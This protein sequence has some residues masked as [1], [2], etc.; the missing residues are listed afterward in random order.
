[1]CKNWLLVTTAFER[2]LNICSSYCSCSKD[3]CTNPHIHTYLLCT[4]PQEE[5]EKTESGNY[6][7]VS[8]RESLYTKGFIK[9]CRRV[10]SVSDRGKNLTQTVMP[11]HNVLSVTECWLFLAKLLTPTAAS[12]IRSRFYLRSS[13]NCDQVVQRARHKIRWQDVYRCCRACVK[14]SA[15]CTETL[16]FN[17][18]LPRCIVCNAVFPMS[19]CPSVRPSVCLS[20]CQTRELWQNESTL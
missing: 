7:P 17:R 8:L 18:F 19:I 6:R 11:T 12:D 14:S 20:V 4:I 3:C 16:A 2:A 13:S 15:N 5:N 9:D 10:M 1:M